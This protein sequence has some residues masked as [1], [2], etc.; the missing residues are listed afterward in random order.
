MNI[1]SESRLARPRATEFVAAGAKGSCKPLLALAL[2]VGLAGC[3]STL[4]DLPPQL[5]GLPA[6][7]PERPAAASVYPAVHDMPPPRQDT[8]LTTDE[9]KK[10]EAELA[11]LRARQAKQAT[12]ATKDK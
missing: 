5:G 7:T 12:A 3:S 6:G 4:G 11:D 9:R 8:V 2:A 10:A 1:V